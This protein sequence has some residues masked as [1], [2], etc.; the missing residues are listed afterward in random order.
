[1]KLLDLVS[2]CQAG[3]ASVAIDSKRQDAVEISSGGNDVPGD[4]QLRTEPAALYAT[5]ELALSAWKAEFDRFAPPRGA[6]ALVWVERPYVESYRITLGDSHGSYRVVRD[7]FVVRGRVAF[8]KHVI[9]NKH[10]F[11]NTNTCVKC[12]AKWEEIMDCLKPA[13][14]PGQSA[15]PMGNPARS[16]PDKDDSN[17]GVTAGKDQQPKIKRKAKAA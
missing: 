5:E 3:F 1:M 14:C 15:E 9:I 13:E 16:V 10:D 17:V 6:N 4:A 7:R 2:A 12:G 8:E 11:D